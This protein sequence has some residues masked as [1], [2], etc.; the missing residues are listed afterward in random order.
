M[1]AP[2]KDC[3]NRH[4]HCHNYCEKYLKFLAENEKRKEVMRLENDTISDQIDRM[5]KWRRR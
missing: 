2:C 4:L 1:V 5:R 3:P